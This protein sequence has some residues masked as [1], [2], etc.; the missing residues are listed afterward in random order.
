MWEIYLKNN[1]TGK[2]FC[3]T[4]WDKKKKDLF[5]NK[6]R[7]SKKLTLIEVLDWSWYYD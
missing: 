3:K 2:S 7:F 4:F 1:L 5:L 6:L